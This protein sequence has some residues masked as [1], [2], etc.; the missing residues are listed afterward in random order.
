MEFAAS[1]LLSLL[2]LLFS[3]LYRI[4]IL[5][6]RLSCRTYILCNLAVFLQHIMRNLSK[7][8]LLSLGFIA[9]G[10]STITTGLTSTPVFADREKNQKLSPKTEYEVDTDI[11]DHNKHT[12]VRPI[13]L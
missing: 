12:I 9:I 1:M 10:L 8:T 7:L 11:R 13:D 4:L 5:S 6:I 3:Y 2:S